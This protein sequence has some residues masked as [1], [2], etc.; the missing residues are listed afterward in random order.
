[1]IAL[2]GPISVSL[3]AAAA[4]AWVL[5]YA[6]IA[7][8]ARKLL[9]RTM[10][11]SCSAIGLDPAVIEFSRFFRAGPDTAATGDLSPDLL[12]EASANH[13]QLRAHASNSLAADT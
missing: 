5:W 13:R 12:R 11:A 7:A 4:F 2:L 6:D 9:E 10:S 1:M 8:V 3:L